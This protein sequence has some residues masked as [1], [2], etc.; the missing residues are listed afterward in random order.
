[1][2]D[3]FTEILHDASL[4][5]YESGLDEPTVCAYLNNYSYDAIC[6][7]QHMVDNMPFLN[8]ES[9]TVMKRCINAV[10]VYKTF[11]GSGRG[12]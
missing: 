12:Y 4:V 2:M 8:D 11:N 3:P 7:C 5:Y 6:T 9:K 10:I 1:M